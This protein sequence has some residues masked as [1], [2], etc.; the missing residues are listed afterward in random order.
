MNKTA[1]THINT[2]SGA[3]IDLLAPDP[4]QF[5]IDDIATSLSRQ[6]RFNGNLLEHHYS[7]AQ[8]SVYVSQLVPKHMALAA[9]LHDGSE[10]VTGD[11]VSPLKRLISHALADIEDRV[12]QAVHLAFS[13]PAQLP[14]DWQESIHRADMAMVIA[15]K[16]HLLPLV[17]ERWDI[18]DHFEAA[19]IQITKMNAEDASTLFLQRFSYLTGQPSTSAQA[20][21][22]Q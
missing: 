5:N 10:M 11:I 18:E 15:E 13:L 16:R 14:E 8:H 12:Q 21:H 20:D 3:K 2:A 4:G 6:C 22:F 9:L 7:V 17:T 1:Q 19:S